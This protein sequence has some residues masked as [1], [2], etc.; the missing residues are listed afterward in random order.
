MTKRRDSGFFT[1]GELCRFLRKL[2]GRTI[3]PKHTPADSD[4]SGLLQLSLS[5]CREL[6][7]RDFLSRPKLKFDLEEASRSKAKKDNAGRK[8]LS[9]VIESLTET[10]RDS[11]ATQARRYVVFVL[12]SLLKDIRVTAGI[13]RGI[14]SFDPN[15]L[16]SQPMDQALFCFRALITAFNCVDGSRR[17]TRLIIVRNMSNSL[18]NFATLMGISGCLTLSPTLSTYS[19][20]CHHYGASHDYSICLDWAVYVWPRAVLTCRLF[21]FEGADSSDPNCRL[22]SVLLPAQSYLTTGPNSVVSCVSESALNKFHELETRFDSG[23]VPGDPWSHVVSFGQSKFYK[24]LMS[25]YKT[26]GHDVSPVKVVRS[27]SSSLVSEGAGTSFRSPGKTVT[28]VSESVIPAAE[29]AKTVKELREGSNK[30]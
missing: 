27:S 19:F 3:L 2:C 13:V 20:P 29:V 15:V 8:N 21:R 5:D 11:F 16:L 9:S 12:D 30:P 4:W 18:I 25:A 28:L 14:A 26:Q 6:S 22:S 23:N 17:P 1:F 10:V 24:A 7:C